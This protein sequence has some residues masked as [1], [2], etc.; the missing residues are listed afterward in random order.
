MGAIVLKFSVFLFCL[1][2]SLTATI[3]HI[4]DDFLT[5]QEGI[6]NALT[7]DTVLVYPG[8]YFEHLDVH[9]G[10]SI[11]S[12]T[13]T[14]GDTSY[15]TQTILDG[16]GLGRVMQILIY[17]SEFNI[18]GLTLQNGYTDFG[19]GGGLTVTG[20]GNIRHCIIRD[21]SSG[22]SGG[23]LTISGF[24][25]EDIIRLEDLQILN[26]TS[27]IGGGGLS[28]FG[29]LLQDAP[30]IVELVRCTI[31]DN[32]GGSGGGINANTHVQMTLTNCVIENNSALFG[33]GLALSGGNEENQITSVIID[34]TRIAGNTSTRGGGIDLGFH[35]HLLLTHSTVE[36]NEADQ[37]GGGIFASD[38]MMVSES[39]LAFNHGGARGG[40]IASWF[41]DFEIQNSAIHH[42]E[43]IWGGGI[44]LTNSSPV[45]AGTSISHNTAMSSGAGMEIDNSLPIFAADNRSS[46]HSN[47]VTLPGMGG[48]EIDLSAA[49]PITVVLDTFTVIEP[50]SYYVSPLASISF[51]IQQGLTPQQSADLFV[52]PGGSDSHT[53]LSSEFPLQT[54][55]RALATILPDSL[56]PLSIH[57]AAG[58]YWTGSN[59]E[60]FPLT[61]VDYV[62]LVG[63]GP[64]LTILDGGGV[65][66]PLAFWYSDDTRVENLTLRNGLGNLG[67]GAN[68]YYSAADFSNL[69]IQNNSAILYGGGISSSHSTVRLTDVTIQDCAANYGGGIAVTGD[70]NQLITENVII[71]GNSCTAGGGGL[72]VASGSDTLRRL[73]IRENTAGTGGGIFVENGDIVLENIEI[74]GNSATT[75]AGVEVGGWTILDLDRITLANNS[76]TEGGGVYCHPYSTVRIQNS[77]FWGNGNQAMVHTGT[78]ELDSLAL[79]YSTVE[80]GSDG[81][82]TNWPVEDSWLMGNLD[83]DPLFI[84]PEESD[85]T[86]QQSSPCIDAG[87]PNTAL[88]PDGTIA[89]M[90]AWFFEQDNPC[91]V[92]GDINGDDNV[93]ILDVV[94][95]VESVLDEILLPCA[96]LNQDGSGDILDIVILVEWILY[97]R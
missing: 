55:N 23:G 32:D 80:N 63:A 65:R 53:G 60:S 3:L 39:V 10:I 28:V 79:R 58:I 95:L 92:P 74:T 83:L 49:E 19:G 72:Y 54:I 11:G 96:D 18:V 21:N 26:N 27:N 46:I 89:D 20:S 31:S 50:T 90:G 14:T 30:L 7:G 64:E 40:G 66:S 76:G 44:H 47:E 35:S 25:G 9:R 2:A 1:L 59:G 56:N 75:G 97:G 91:G 16:S 71:R 4:P 5:V 67:G 94:L 68:I 6:D 69:I 12:L 29:G 70:D 62:T 51:D 36:Y 86:L 82:L 77:I 15:I 13:L 78:Y 93:D 48:R 34:S 73:I 45:I 57:C 38:S 87:N 37:A 33:G 61:M 84:N 41:S 42:N 8:T 52:D 22:T 88:D 81:L 85:F 24:H 17:N 43:A